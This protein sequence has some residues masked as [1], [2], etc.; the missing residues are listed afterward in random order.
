MLNRGAES[1]QKV[2][3]DIALEM[4]G[5]V[6]SRPISAPPLTVVLHGDKKKQTFPN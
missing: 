1:E 6:L 5:L 3:K 4:L 2:S